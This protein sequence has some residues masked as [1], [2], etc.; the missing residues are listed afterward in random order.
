MPLEIKYQDGGMTEWLKVTVLKTV[1]PLWY[2]GF[3]SPSLRFCQALP[4]V[5]AD[6]AYGLR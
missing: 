4:N 2:R 6:S 1:V 3:E 5:S